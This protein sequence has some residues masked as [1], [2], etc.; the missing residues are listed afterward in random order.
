MQSANVKQV[1]LAVITSLEEQ[2]C[3]ISNITHDTVA[4]AARR[5]EPRLP[6]LLPRGGQQ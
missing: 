2:G 5:I 3:R 4:L 6:D 1:V